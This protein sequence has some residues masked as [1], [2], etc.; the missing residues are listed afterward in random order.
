MAGN[1]GFVK[2]KVATGKFPASTSVS[3]VNCHSIDCS[4]FITTT[5]II[6]IIRG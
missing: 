6:I 2:D 1:M 4:T 5:I 3:R